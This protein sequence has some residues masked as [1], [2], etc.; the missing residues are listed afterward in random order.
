MSQTLSSAVDDEGE[1]S[2]VSSMIKGSPSRRYESVCAFIRFSGRRLW[3]VNRLLYVSQATDHYFFSKKQK[4][5]WKA[6]LAESDGECFL[7]RARVLPTS[8][9]SVMWLW[10]WC[11][12]CALERSL[13]V[14]QKRTCLVSIV[15]LSLYGN[16]RKEAKQ[17][18]DFGITDW[19]N[20]T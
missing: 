2:G 1:R 16:Q 15:S 12:F 19:Y 9:T 11:G 10:F 6:S 8:N 13:I 5:R 3:P 20:H 4:V 7:T 18:A 17:S 14:L